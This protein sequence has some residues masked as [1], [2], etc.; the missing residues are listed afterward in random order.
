MT[1]RS[2][3]FRAARSSQWLT[4]PAKPADLEDDDP[5]IVSGYLSCVYFGIE[6][7]K[8]D[9]EDQAPKGDKV[10]EE[11]KVIKDAFA[12][13]RQEC[14]KRYAED[15]CEE[16]PYTA[17]CEAHFLVLAKTYLQADKLQDLTTVKMIIDEFIRF[18][19]TMRR[20]PDIGTIN[21]VY[22]ST[23]HGSPLRKLMR[24]YIVHE[25]RSEAY[26][27]FHALRYHE[28]FCR[29]ILVEFLRAQD[30]DPLEAMQC[31]QELG[32][33]QKLCADICNYH[34]HED[35]CVRCVSELEARFCGCVKP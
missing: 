1:Q 4:D 11:D 12:W 7:L 35:R 21:L 10:D 3:F 27:D 14:E 22:E 13:S 20:N 19:L 33:P 5:E 2:E 28:D 15:A 23:V 26:L 8:A 29:D 17:A 31:Q 6:A 9:I 25:N 18:S 24:D 34:I 32:F 30:G 16:T